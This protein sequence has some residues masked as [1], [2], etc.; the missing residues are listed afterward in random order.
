MAKAN[1]A[2]SE[3]AV[4]ALKRVTSGWVAIRQ[5]VAVGRCGSSFEVDSP[6]IRLG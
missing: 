5:R 1:K 4:A 2:P 3:V 6:I